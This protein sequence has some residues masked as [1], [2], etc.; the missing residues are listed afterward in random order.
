MEIKSIDNN[1]RGVAATEGIER[2]VGLMLIDDT[3][4]GDYVI[5]HAGFAIEKLDQ[6]EAQA[7]L[8]LFDQL[9]EAMAQ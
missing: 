1:Q 2:E 7:R 9:A 3:R 5:V 8:E 4:V 6:E